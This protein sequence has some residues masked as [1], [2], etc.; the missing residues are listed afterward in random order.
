MT[1]QTRDYTSDLRKTLLR[2]ASG[3]AML[4]TLS[5]CETASSAFDSVAGV[6]DSDEEPPRADGAPTAFP[7]SAQRE[8]DPETPPI[9]T[10]PDRP[11]A[12]VEARRAA[13]LGGIEGEDPYQAEAELPGAPPPREP[14]LAPVQTA[15][16]PAP[17]ALPSQQPVD[18]GPAF[19]TTGTP[20][21][22]FWPG[23]PASAQTR[24]RAPDP[25]PQRGVFPG[26]ATT[27]ED[28]S[29][30]TQPID[31]D[32]PPPGAAPAPATTASAPPP[33][34]TAPPPARAAAPAPAPV[35]IEDFSRTPP[36]PPAVASAPPPVS[37]APAPVPAQGGLWPGSPAPAPAPAPAPVPAGQPV[38]QWTG[39]PEPV[40]DAPAS[41]GGGLWPGSPAPAPTPVPAGQ[42]A[43]VG[44]AP[45]RQAEA[46]TAQT[47]YDRFYRPGAPTYAG[48]T[49]HVPT[50]SRRSAAPA[51]LRDMPPFATTMRDQQALFSRV[52]RA[53]PVGGGRRIATLFFEDGSSAFTADDREVLR[54]VADLYRQS[55]GAIRIEGHAS[56]PT[57]ARDR[58]Q[59]N[60]INY[61]VSGDRGDRVAQELVRLGVPAG[62]I[63]ITV[64]SDNAPEYAGGGDEA[65]NRRVVLYLV[66]G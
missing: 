19:D 6:F 54:A 66:A 45:V 60:L 33:V 44:P 14:D 48:A 21:G 61:D 20:S 3:A 62:R 30:L 38:D 65:A 46:P 43:P 41:A 25:T 1:D 2:G 52:G 10:T 64:L 4:L 37:A 58:V 50:L 5:A 7:S 51:A 28:G 55:G 40:F 23:A 22:G 31:E 32:L 36:P 57:R 17:G 63:M 16:A 56:R 39:E 49:P 15:Q 8:P 24:A 59:H 18:D 42:P 35:P 13:I 27:F 11:D 47:A 53:L 12:D 34:S 29:T 26:A 9:G